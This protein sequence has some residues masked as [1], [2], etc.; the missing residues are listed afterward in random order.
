MCEILKTFPYWI[1]ILIMLIPVV[2]LMIAAI[3]LAINV[4]QTILNNTLVKAKMVSDS[5]HIFMNDETIQVAFYK[6]E[7]GD[8]QYG[9]DFHG[10]N[11]E[12]EIDKL[13]R[14]FSNL[15]IMWKNGLLNIDD[16]FP[17]QYFILRA[18]NNNQVKKY[19]EFID[20][21]SKTAG[22]GGHPYVALSE[23]CQKL[24]SNR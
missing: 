22:T 21:W 6:I 15:A 4:R 17:I 14:H 7:Y 12:K 5:L 9:P 2:S 3:A 19:M 11:E 23:L 10:S 24:E 16:I 13:L 20:H 1:Q 18:V 8:F